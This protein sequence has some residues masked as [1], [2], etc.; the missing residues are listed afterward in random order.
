MARD[1]KHDR[2]VRGA[3]GA[4][5]Q[6]SQDRLLRHLQLR[7][8]RALRERVQD[9][10]QHQFDRSSIPKNFDEKSFV[11]FAGDVCIIPPNSFALA[12]TVEYFRIPRSVLTICLGKCV[13]ADTRVVDADTGALRADHRDAL[14]QKHAGHGRLDAE[15]RESLGLRA[16]RARSRSSSCARAQGCGSAPPPIIPSA[17]CRAGCRL[18]SSRPGDRIAVA[19]NIPVFGKT[20]IPDW[21]ASLLG[22]MISEGQC[23]T[24]GHSPT[25]TSADPVLV[26]LLKASVAASG[27]GGGDLQRS[28]TAIGWSIGA[29]AAVFRSATGLTRG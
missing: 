10:H 29:A 1:H 7:L 27:T 15:A 16:A 5:G 6:R 11:D 26:R 20:P 8:R 21:E 28:A 4:A 3:A 14:R 17:C 12:R 18:E 13:T 19:R 23:H 9:L 22:L 25:F 2:A 24:P